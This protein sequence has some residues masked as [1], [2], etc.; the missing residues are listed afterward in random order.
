MP[1]LRLYGTKKKKLELFL[2]HRKNWFIAVSAAVVEVALE[3][4]LELFSS[5]FYDFRYSKTLS[6][7]LC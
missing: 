5:G 6:D 4:S 1:H 7:N 3:F 2:N